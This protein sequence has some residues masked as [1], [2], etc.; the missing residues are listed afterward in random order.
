[1][2]IIRMK[3]E[4]SMK[5][6]KKVIAHLPLCYSLA[7]LTWR[8]EYC[9]LAAAEN[10]GP[11]CLF[12]ED[13]TQIDTPWETP[14]GTMTMQQ[15]PGSDGVF[16]ATHGFYSPD[17]SRE[18]RIVIC[19]PE[20]TDD[21]FEYISQKKEEKA[22][23]TEKAEITEKGLQANT[24][25]NAGKRL[26][27]NTRWNV[28]T[29]ITAPF[30]H[31]FGI[32]ERGGVHYLLICCLKSGYEYE[33]DWRFPGAVYAAVLPEE[34]ARKDETSVL[35]QL[36][37]QKMKDGMLKNHG[38]CYC[39]FD[40]TDHALITCE[41]GVFLFT[42]PPKAGEEWE[43]RKLLDIPTSDAVLADFDGDGLPELG[44]IEEFHGNRFRIFR[45]KS[46]WEDSRSA[47]ADLENPTDAVP[48]GKDT[49]ASGKLE[50]WGEI[51]N[52]PVE[53]VPCWEY[54]ERLEML[55]AIWAGKLAGKECIVIGNR[56]G[57]RKTLLIYW[58]NGQYA[59]EVLDEGTGAANVMHFVNREGQDVIVAANR[60]TDTITMYENFSF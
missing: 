13:G 19:R 54:P 39:P 22:E 43:I 44:I 8:G 30:V 49:N 10:D 38:Y 28:R 34:L 24:R 52:G 50:S 29:L 16:L 45:L 15:V 33:G 57:E 18:A 1:M 9:F 48:N 59:A 40:G 55:H 23:K 47:L 35:K 11:C 42:P 3:G 20:M 56:H 51:L 60:E 41:D 5:F 7:G 36:P 26:Q 58:K 17:H 14:G 53:F 25:W 32:L 31:R 21:S 2:A 37:V 12:S 46:T 4:S 27:T 6:T